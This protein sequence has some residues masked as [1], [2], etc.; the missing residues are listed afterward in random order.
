MRPQATE[1]LEQQAWAVLANVPDPEIP[2]IS[3]VDLGIVRE[4]RW[5][6]SND[7]PC[8]V[9]AVTPTYSGCPATEV[10]AQSIREALDQQGFGQA[11]IETR[12][13]PA[14]TTDWLSAEGR[15]KLKAYG[16]VPPVARSST[17]H[18]IDIS[19]ITR[20]DAVAPIVACPRCG[21]AR[22]EVISEFG[23]TP[24]KSLYRCTACREPFDYFKPH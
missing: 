11:Q 2:V 17:E 23:S 22:T 20:R 24:C 10:I 15:A 13:A 18:V 3:I 5:D 19:R 1:V 7:P 16:I 21:S 12:L 14:W 9:V 6:D 8:L 4:V